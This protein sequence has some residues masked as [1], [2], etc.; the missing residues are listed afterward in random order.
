M[1][2]IVNRCVS[3][4]CL[5]IMTAAMLSLSGCGPDRVGETFL[6]YYVNDARDDIVYR[7]WEIENSESMSCT[8]RTEA[9]LQLLFEEDLEE[10]HLHSAKP[11]DVQII[12]FTA[13]DNRL[14]FNFNNNYLHMTNVEEILLRAALVL[15]MIQQSDVTQVIFTVDGSPLTDSSGEVIGR[16]NAGN[17]VDILLTEEGM[18]RQETDLTLFFTDETGT[19]LI[20]AM[21]HFTINNSNSSMEEYIL[22][23]LKN[24]P[25]I[26]STYRTMADNV[27]IIS[28]MTKDNV[29]NVNFGSNFLTQEQPVSD[30]IMIYSIVNSLCSLPYVDSVQFLVEGK[31]DVVLHTVMDLS[32]PFS[33]NRALEQ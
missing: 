26:D 13:E 25:A 1:K 10:Q 28:V 3:I 12:D 8:E 27:E 18:L 20:P 23:Q 29:C 2:R 6:V 5:T 33:R 4:L 19:V 30:E 7:E 17:F 11:E 16:M 22:Q 24:G 9:L 32:A 14:T 21:Y 31:S 15:T